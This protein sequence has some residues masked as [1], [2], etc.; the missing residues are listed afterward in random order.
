MADPQS[1]LNSHNQLCLIVS[2]ALGEMPGLPQ[3]L[4]LKSEVEEMLQLLNE[5]RQSTLIAHPV[6]LMPQGSDSGPRNSGN[7]HN[8][9]KLCKHARFN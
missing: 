6:M 7:R 3:L 1:A 2:S 4:G 9:A 8:A 5:V